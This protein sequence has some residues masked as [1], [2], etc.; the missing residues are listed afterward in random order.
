MYGP[1]ER[2]Y[3]EEADNL[4]HMVSE[5]EEAPEDEH[6]YADWLKTDMW[7]DEDKSDKA[8]V[9]DVYD[10]WVMSGG[11]DKPVLPDYLDYLA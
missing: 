4:A 3:A 5:R 11:S 10:I 7:G 8:E 1:D 6:L 9:V 2:D